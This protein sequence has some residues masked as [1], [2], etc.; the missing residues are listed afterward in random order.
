[1]QQSEKLSTSQMQFPTKCLSVAAN[2][3]SPEPSQ[4]SPMKPNAAQKLNL[5][6]SPRLPVL[7]L[8]VAALLIQFAAPEAW[9]GV[10][11]TTFTIQQGNLQK[12]GSAYGSGTGYSGVVDG[13]LNDNNTTTALS[14]TATSTLGNAFASGSPNGRQYVGQFSY[15]L[16]ELN[17]FIAANTGPYSSVA[18]QSVSFQIISAGSVSGTASSIGLYGTDPFTSSCTWANYTTG[19]PWTIPYQNL[20]SPNNTVQY[21]YTGGGSRLTTSLATANPNTGVTT[22]N[23][24][25]WTS[26]AN[27]ITA[28]NNA[29][30]R[31]D[32]KL[33]LTADVGAGNS[34]NRLSVNYSPTAT[35]ASR[36]QLTITLQITT[37]A[38]PTTWTG[39]SDTS[40]IT[41]GNWSPSTVPLTDSPIIFN[42]SS[43]ANLNT[44]LNQNFTILSLSLTN[45]TGPV[46]IGG[47]NSLTID[48]GGIDLSAATQNLTVSA[49][50]VLGVGQTWNVAGSR[51]LSV[52]GGVSGS[53]GLTVSGPGKV[54]LGGA[55]TYTGDT[56]VSAGGTLQMGAA[57]VLPSG[58]GVGN[59]VVF[60]TLDLNNTAESVN[61]LNGSG[62]VNHTGGGAATLMVGNNNAANTNF[63]GVIQNTSGTLALVK[64]GTGSLTLSG[65][66]TYS[67]GTTLANGTV[68]PGNGSAFG[69]G[70]IAVNSGAIVYPVVTMT[71]TNALALNGGYLH[72]G[73]GSS[74]AVIWSGPVTVTNG[75]TMAG[76][77][78]GTVN[79]V[80]GP[81]DIGT[82]GI[83]V[84]NMNGN[85]QAQANLG[86]ILSGTISG[87]GDVTYYLHNGNSR[88]TVNG[89]NTYSGNTV[90]NQQG[91]QVG[92]KLNVASVPQNVN[93]YPFSTGTVT[94][95]AGAV[96]E[97]YPKSAIITN[98]LILNG[99]T[100][101]SESQFNDYNTLTWAGPI[102]LTANSTLLQY[103]QG[104]L[105]NNQS[106]GVTVSGS[107]N[108]NGFTLTNT[109]PVLCFNGNIISG[110]ISGAGT[111]LHY[112]NNLAIS[113]SNTFT[114][115]FR[116]VGGTLT[117]QNAYALQNATLDM[118]AADSGTVTLI[119]NAVI[120]ALTG[121]RNL[122]MGGFA[123]SI[124]NNNS[125]TTYNGN[126]TNSGSI[127]K[128]GTG[129]L[130]LSGANN[131]T[132]G[133]TISAGTVALSGSGSLASSVISVAGGATF[134]TS[135]ATFTLGS[136][137]V[138]S[139]SASATASLIGPLDA[140]SG[141]I[142]MSFVNGTP[143]FNVA[144][145]TLNLS[146]S[147]V[148]AVRNTGAA[149]TP[150]TYK[151][152]SASGGGTVSGTAPTS[153]SV[154]NGPVAG[155]PI[156]SIVGGELYLT[157][158]GTS[159]IGYSG[160]LFTYYGAAQG[161]A[162]SYI[163]STGIRTTNYVGTGLT[164]YA[165]INA[166]TNVG[167][168]YVSNTV[169]ADASYFGATN[170]QSFT[171]VP[172]DLGITANDT[173][174]SF[175]QTV[176][177]LGTEFTTSGL[178]GGDSLSSVTLTSAGATNAANVGTYS[179]VPS[180]ASGTG[181]GN[182]T[183]T[184]TSGTLTVNPAST[185]VGASSTMNP[186][187][188][189]DAISFIAT[190]P[191]DATGSVVFSSTNGPISTNNIAAGS[192]TSFSLTNL[193]R[194]TNAITVAYLGDSNYMG[195]TN[196]LEQTVT[197]HP[198]V[199]ANGT[200]YR[201]K[202]V[203][204][205]IA[206]PELFTNVTDVDGDAFTLQNVG[207]GLTNATIMTD[208]NYVYYLPGTG[209]GSDDNDIISYTVDDG[210]GGTAAANILINVYSATGQAQMSIPTNG[211]VNITFFG[212]PNYT[213]VVQT[214]TNLSVP[215]WILSTN[216]AGTNG[217]W[218]FTDPNATN[219]QQ[220]YRSAQ[221]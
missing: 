155:T 221:P 109:A 26:S 52:N 27:F 210:F 17:T 66:N 178:F 93:V 209:A 189:K 151:I 37:T 98:A 72:V 49:P 215:W 83:Y 130:T 213:Y 121:S 199:A 42:G 9:A 84:T 73:G 162:I 153:V 143:S 219:S 79:K 190:L 192:A 24:L 54:S 51:T 174:K 44:V 112:I 60:G 166:P 135:A 69:T 127:T 23:P 167:S 107:L 116:A 89:T 144:S 18:I 180:A 30:A 156:L 217:I 75:F 92:G 77:N 96:I 63:T 197:N 1:M 182:Y 147:T 47:A 168:Y 2:L 108:M 184:Y 188:Y 131:Y 120:G 160:T 216:T 175:G 220:Y 163:G 181:L 91:G 176:T 62:I 187:G 29:L 138:I 61:A 161:S 82:G 169:A 34:D 58:A 202:G 122:N 65:T 88:L 28:V 125:S 204:L 100:L 36:P 21:G 35:V 7:A 33:Y 5:I 53:V 48:S 205:K 198:P 154:I 113:G 142:L 8:M 206:L 68:V 56:T 106:S 195:S 207:A 39:A 86:D 67:G 208:S 139:N 170:A 41:A 55:A 110:P 102:I 157:V 212:I 99:G 165:S 164:T 101:E 146:A 76:D 74:S 78:S 10:V 158:G 140:G 149:L 13:Q 90:I 150:G 59:M 104:A 179:I 191:A 201:A 87:S 200:F 12:D 70:T 105:N 211:V 186:S 117:V 103:G 43:T 129:T 159:S 111:I 15:D 80:S 71:I 94:L 148:V 193:L 3:L 20:A 128:I 85:G 145:G 141:T 6:T 95:N 133:L 16:T 25:I 118:N 137:Q 11:T 203:S 173:N 4:D 97:A 14:T 32:K 172:A 196:A 177:F 22:G 185:F 50:V 126:L 214:T 31:S 218:Q 114:G 45:P 57:N 194:G 171:I 183:I 115:T 38:A 123:V 132:N 152:I 64:V 81:M 119:N 19:T 46:S 124:G 136:A 134:D 40:W